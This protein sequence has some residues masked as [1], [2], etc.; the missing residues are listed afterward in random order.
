MN[1]NPKI[2]ERIRKMLNLAEN[3]GATIH[4]S[5][6][7]AAMA[8][9]LMAKYN[10]DRSAI[11]LEGIRRDDITAE[12]TD[13]GH[14]SIPR[15]VHRL[16]VPVARLFDCEA[17]AQRTFRDG[18]RVL[19]FRVLGQNEDAQVASWTFHYLVAEI[20]RLS[21][22][23]RRQL[24]KQYGAGHGFNMGDYRDGLV[25]EILITIREA[26]EAK[27]RMEKGHT[28]GTALVVR[29]QALIREKFPHAGRYSQMKPKS[30]SDGRA[31]AQGRQDGKNVRLN[32]PI[33]R[34]T[35]GRIA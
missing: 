28:T 10:I 11:T 33:Q 17:D 14:T 18:K 1:V 21:K 30:P 7:A 13:T 27:D 32:Q 34:D 6:T 2:I 4:E 22:V 3:P 29:K 23:Y 35:R 12:A 15:W 31:Y 16:I 26:Q 25:D 9:K 20:E 24:R 5:A 8:S 19:Y